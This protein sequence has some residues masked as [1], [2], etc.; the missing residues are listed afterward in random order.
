VSGR[1]KTTVRLVYR[2][3]ASND[4]QLDVVAASPAIFTNFAGGSDALVLNQ[5][6]TLNGASNPAAAGSVVAIFATGAGQMEPAG[7][8]G[9]PAP[10]AS[11]SLRATLTIAGRP[12][13]I[14]YAGPA[15][16]L[17]GVAQINARV[18]GG[19]AGEIQ[20]AP[21]VLTIGGASSRTGVILWIR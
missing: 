4:V 6:G 18:P 21:I 5:D 12:A 11:N 15:P 8:T 14:L 9:V 3:V 16:T 20:R 7:V 13:E 10:G 2:E 17:V 1:G 19:L